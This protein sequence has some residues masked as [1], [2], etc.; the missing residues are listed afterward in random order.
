ML[1]FDYDQKIIGLYKN[2]EESGL[3]IKEKKYYIYILILV[4]LLIILLLIFIFIKY[5]IKKPERK[6]RKNELD[7][8]F[9]YSIQ[10]NND[11]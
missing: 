5:L 10:G 9:D 4:M 7:D 2:K 3:N 1:V 6:I 8:D 11:A